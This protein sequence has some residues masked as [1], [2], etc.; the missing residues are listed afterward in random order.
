MT[1]LGA[2]GGM[3]YDTL[4]SGRVNEASLPFLQPRKFG[5]R[6][7]CEIQR[8]PNAA[9]RTPDRRGTLRRRVLVLPDDDKVDVAVRPR[10]GPGARAEQQDH[11]R[12]KLVDDSPDRF[13]DTQ[14]EPL[15][16]H[17]SERVERPLAEKRPEAA[18][19]QPPSPQTH[20]ARPGRTGTGPAPEANAAAQSVDGRPDPILSCASCRPCVASHVAGTSCRFLRH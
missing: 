16:V 2:K 9:K 7:D 15:L 8:D 4:P 18:P 12:L 5:R 19:S 11:R 6:D 1:A 3:K 14:V 13:L 20:E 17:D 10:L